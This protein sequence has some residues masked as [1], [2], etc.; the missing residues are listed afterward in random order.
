MFRACFLQP[1]ALHPA[2]RPAEFSAF[3]RPLFYGGFRAAFN[4]GL[5]I[6]HIRAGG[7]V[8]GEGGGQKS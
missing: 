8:E 3:R 6:G 7:E 4:L 2:N 1:P 5:H